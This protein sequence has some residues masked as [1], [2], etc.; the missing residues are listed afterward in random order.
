VAVA[1][2]AV[3]ADD[4][5]AAVRALRAG[6]APARKV[7]VVLASSVQGRLREVEGIRKEHD[8]LKD[9]VEILRKTPDDPAA[10][11]AV[12]RYLCFF[13]DK[14][15]RGL[16]LLAKSKDPKLAP[17]AAKELA[18]PDKPDDLAELADGWIGLAGGLEPP[19][20]VNLQMH[21]YG[22]YRQALPGLTGGAKNKVE[23]RLPALESVA[24]SR[25]DLHEVFA[26]IQA[27]IKTSKLAETPVIGGLFDK[28][29]PAAPP[30]G[31]LLL[32]FE[33]SLNPLLNCNFI[34]SLRPIYLTAQG[35][36]FGPTVGK[37]STKVATFKA[38]KGFAVAGVSLRGNPLFGIEGMSITYM[39]MGEKALRKDTAYKTDWIGGGKDGKTPETPL[40]GDG[41][42]VVGINPKLNGEGVLLGLGLLQLPP[43]PK[44]P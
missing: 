28:P 23:N 13:K 37:V 44:A 9:A 18:G 15:D 38:K 21:A 27:A 20:K 16:P 35:E 43:T 5:E 1:G 19:A 41:S 11:L 39:K 17:L 4:F 40:A 6:E 29:T 25:R 8:R 22:W 32:G 14:W 36:K 24:E 26:A 3:G 30:E 12:G 33:I 10:N 7:S 2:E 34:S 31:A 42:P